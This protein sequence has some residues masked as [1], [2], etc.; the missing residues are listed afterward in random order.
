MQQRKFVFHISESVRTHSL[1]FE[2]HPRSRGRLRSMMLYGCSFGIFVRRSYES[3]VQLLRNDGFTFDGRGSRRDGLK[4]ADTADMLSILHYLEIIACACPEALEA[5]MIIASMAAW[6]GI[7]GLVHV[8]S[9]NTGS[10]G[11]FGC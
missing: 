4:G 2:H 9:V 11:D 3:R 5:Y 8:S 10:Y 1:Q 7:G 6:H